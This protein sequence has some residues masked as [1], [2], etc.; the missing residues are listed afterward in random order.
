MSRNE[1][2][3]EGVNLLGNQGVKYP[4]DYAP[5]LLETFPNKHCD[6]E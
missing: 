1:K 4:I 5:E 6:N 2:E 3:L